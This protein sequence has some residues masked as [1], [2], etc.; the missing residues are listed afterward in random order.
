MTGNP[1]PDEVLGIE[2][3]YITVHDGAVTT[4][5]GISLSVHTGEIVGLVGESGSGKTLTCRAALGRAAEGLRHQR[6]RSRS[7]GRT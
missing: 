1:P 6:G 4:V 5:R 2:D 3:L 7:S